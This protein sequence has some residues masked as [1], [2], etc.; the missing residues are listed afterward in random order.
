[1]KNGMHGF[2]NPAPWPAGT[3]FAQDERAGAIMKQLRQL[4]AQRVASDSITAM[5]RALFLLSSVS[6][7][8]MVGALCATYG[9]AVPAIVATLLTLAMSMAL[10][11]ASDLIVQN[12]APTVSPARFS[13]GVAGGEA[14]TASPRGQA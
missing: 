5:C 10:G 3:E 13:E 9:S 7:F 11:M 2:Q 12:I 4:A 8:I 6:F 14:A 1:M